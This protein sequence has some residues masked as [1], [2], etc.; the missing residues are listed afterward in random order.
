MTQLARG[1]PPSDSDVLSAAGVLREER[2]FQDEDA[3]QGLVHAM[4][5]PP[6]WWG[7]SYVFR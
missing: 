2:K 4:E 7:V 6:A 1:R 3:V 5:V